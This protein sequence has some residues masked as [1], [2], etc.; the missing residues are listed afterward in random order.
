MQKFSKEQ[1]QN[2]NYL[3]KYSRQHNR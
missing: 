2:Y 1:L 3:S